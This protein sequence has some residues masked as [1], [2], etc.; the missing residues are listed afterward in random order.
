MP[1]TATVLNV[2]I[3]SP[4]DVAEER[5]AIAQTLYEWNALNSQT[6]GYILLPVRWESHSAPSMGD[7]PQGII[8]NQVVRGC[9]VLIGS[10]WTR[11]GSPTGVEESGTVEEIR[12]FLKSNRP[13]M[14]YYSRKNVDLD[15]IDTRQLESLKK[16]KES[17]RDKGLQET[18]NSVE[19]LKQKLLRHLTIVMRDINVSPTIDRASIKEA[20]A[21]TGTTPKNRASTADNVTNDLRLEEYTD[22]SF[23]VLGNTKDLKDQMVSEGGKWIKLK[24][25]GYGWMFSKRHLKKIAILLKLPDELA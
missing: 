6:S 14:L 8:N 20:K 17:V 7:R 2:L 19:D 5:E 3:A 13:V 10:F 11:L 4:S 24:A 21:S 15:V 9:D 22:R 25:G 18:Y 1:F 23:V 16:F 12:Y